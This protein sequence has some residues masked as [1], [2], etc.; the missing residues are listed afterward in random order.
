MLAGGRLCLQ[1]GQRVYK[2]ALRGMGH[3][4]ASVVHKL[5]LMIRK[6]GVSFKECTFF[7]PVR[8]PY[9]ILQDIVLNNFECAITNTTELFL[10]CVVIAV[11]LAPSLPE[12][13][14]LYDCFCQTTLGHFSP[15]SGR[16]SSRLLFRTYSCGEAAI[17]V[18]NCGSN[19]RRRNHSGVTI[20][21]PSA[22]P[23][24]A[25]SRT[26]LPA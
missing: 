2:A 5:L 9:I 22:T 7:T 1:I 19:S 26:R 21:A 8:F 4:R 14:T 16:L 13:Q 6:I 10:A 25:R 12:P 3:G 18:Q 15:G 24:L 23:D 17:S 20:H 11:S